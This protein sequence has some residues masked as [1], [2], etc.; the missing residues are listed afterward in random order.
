M[1]T[2]KRYRTTRI[3]VGAQA[4]RDRV[5]DKS[6]QRLCQAYREWYVGAARD[7]DIGYLG[8]GGGLCTELG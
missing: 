7:D 3:D 6:I 4:S 2:T 8:V 1:Y 5:V